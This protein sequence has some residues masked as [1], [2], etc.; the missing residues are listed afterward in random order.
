MSQKKS[1]GGC[2]TRNRQPQ[3]LFCNGDVKHSAMHLQSYLSP[4]P[5]ETFCTE[6]F[7]EECLAHHHG[8]LG[9][10]RVRKDAIHIVVTEYFGNNCFR[11]PDS[12]FVFCELICLAIEMKHFYWNKLRTWWAYR[13]DA[14]LNWDKRSAS[15]AR[16][17][18]RCVEGFLRMNPDFVRCGCIRVFFFVRVVQLE[19]IVRGAL[20]RRFPPPPVCMSE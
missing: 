6:R 1:S 13:P 5:G 12:R 2:R 17:H 8:R 16:H 11:K 19:I 15:I 20:N 10:W 14:T 7:R 18:A 3:L 4:R 9:C